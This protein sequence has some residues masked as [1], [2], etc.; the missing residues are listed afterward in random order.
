MYSCM[1]A[2]VLYAFSHSV[3]C[4]VSRSILCQY[5]CSR[6]ILTASNETFMTS[7]LQEQ[8]RHAIVIGDSPS[9]VCSVIT[10]SSDEEDETRRS[11]KEYV[12]FFNVSPCLW[13]SYPRCTSM[14][15]Q[16]GSTC[17]D[18][19]CLYVCC[20]AATCVAPTA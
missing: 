11:P 17:N 8:P 15:A 16:C 13:S 19:M 1:T 4:N 3:W 14:L 6:N 12:R 9:P 10:I 18:V 2:I 20:A 7:L 5:Y